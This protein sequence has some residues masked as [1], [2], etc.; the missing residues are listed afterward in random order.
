M[1][2]QKAI[3]IELLNFQ[4]RAQALAPQSPEIQQFNNS[5]K[6]IIQLLNFQAQACPPWQPGA[7]KFNN[8]IIQRQKAIFVE[9]LNY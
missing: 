7:W 4:A 3:F 5:M 6:L 8:S 2:R 9:L 1:P